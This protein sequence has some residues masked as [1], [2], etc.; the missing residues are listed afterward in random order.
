MEASPTTTSPDNNTEPKPEENKYSFFKLFS[1]AT[2]LDLALIC[3]GIITSAGAGTLL[4]LFVILFGNSIDAFND[5]NVA[6][7]YHKATDIASKMAIIGGAAF[8]LHFSML[9][10]VLRDL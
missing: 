9:F 10:V 6:K 2:P 5:P 3:C 7:L 1:F 8:I 4:Q